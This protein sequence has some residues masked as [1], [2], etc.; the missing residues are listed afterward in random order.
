MRRLYKSLAVV[1]C[2]MFLVSCASW[3]QLSKDEQARVVLDITQEQLSTWREAGKQWVLALPETTDEEKELKL[4]KAKMWNSNV[5]PAMQVANDWIYSLMQELSKAE[6]SLD[7]YA[8]QR[9]VNPYISRVVFLLV[10]MG[11]IPE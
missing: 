4:D 1:F 11:Y 2:L 8:V 3:E 5:L 7:R 6:G 9:L 10:E